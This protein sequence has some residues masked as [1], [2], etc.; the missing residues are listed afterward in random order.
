M[1]RGTTME[2]N[3]VI[4]YNMANSSILEKRSHIMSQIYPKDTFIEL[5]L[6]NALWHKGICYRK[7]LKALPGTL[8]IAIT[9]YRIASFCDSGFFHG[10]D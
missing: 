7:N 4:W 10:K 5:I 9:K 8:Y 2:C 1:V 3:V 6:C